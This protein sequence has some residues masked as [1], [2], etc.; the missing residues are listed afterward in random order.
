M[1]ERDQRAAFIDKILERAN[2][3]FA[4][5]ARIFR[6]QLFRVTFAAGASVN[7]DV[8]ASVGKNDNVKCSVQIAGAHLLVLNTFYVEAILLQ[9]EARPAFVDGRNEGFVKA[10]STYLHRQY[11]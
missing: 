4:D 8:A 10:S 9:D 5:A 2:T 7:K 1:R 11:A 6:R 3:F